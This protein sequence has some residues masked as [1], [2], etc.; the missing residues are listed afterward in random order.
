MKKTM[1]IFSSCHLPH[2]PAGQHRPVNVSSQV[3]V[4]GNEDRL[5]KRSTKTGERLTQTGKNVNTC[6]GKRL[7]RQSKGVSKDRS[8]GQRRQKL[9][10]LIKQV[11]KVITDRST[12]LHKQDQ[13]R[14]RQVKKSTQTGQKVTQTG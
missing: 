2:S 7:G 4:K 10:M 8:K 11:K 13:S 14:H 3:E 5:V 1:A 6:R 9:K 12:D